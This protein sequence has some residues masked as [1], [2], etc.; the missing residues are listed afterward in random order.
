MIQ[1]DVADETVYLLSSQA[2][3]K[4]LKHAKK[5]IDKGNLIEIEEIDELD[6]LV[7]REDYDKSEHQDF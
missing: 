4:R 3:A 6:R 2:N 5:E 1:V 7:D